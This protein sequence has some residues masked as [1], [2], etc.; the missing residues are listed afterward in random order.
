MQNVITEGKGEL[1]AVDFIGPLPR[2]SRGLRHILVCVD[3]F[4]KAVRLYAIPRPTTRSALN[5]ILKTYVPE[6]GNT[7]RILSD[8]GSQ[9]QNQNWA[10]TLERHGIQAV[11][12]SI[13][14]PQGN[15]AERVNKELGKFFRIYCHEQHSKWPEYV[16]FFEDAINSGYNETTGYTPEELDTGKKPVRFW[17]RYINIPATQNLPVPY[18]CINRITKDRIIRKGRVRADRF[19]RQHKLQTFEKGETILLKANPV[20]SSVENKMAKFYRLF[21]GPY[22][23]GRR[24]GRHTFMVLDTERNRVVGK[25]HASS[26]RKYYV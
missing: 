15:L 11:L 13:R 18:E 8:Q 20:A 12:T 22:V 3:V 21:V 10:T 4:T 16:Q 6:H 23:L 26:F 7:R 14:H 24:L 5:A 1:V 25:Y 9:F 19:D 17:R 2:A